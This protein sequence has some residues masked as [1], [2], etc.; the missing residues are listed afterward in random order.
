MRKHI[1]IDGIELI[2]SDDG[3]VWTPERDIVYS[4]GRKCHYKEK[5]LHPSTTPQGYK[6]IA[7]HGEIYFSFH[8]HRLIAI[9][10]IPN[11][12]NLSCV[13]HKDG[14][15]QNNHVSNLEWC[16]VE[17]NNKH[18]LK[19]GLIGKYNPIMCIETGEMFDSL[20]ECS[21]RFNINISYLG[22][23]LKGKYKQCKGHH[24]KFIES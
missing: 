15:K 16:T 4:N 22:K 24:F 7:H 12:N 14:N 11:P 18:A 5:E 9:T 10:F 2:V 3:R 8:V 13:N 17:Y 1:N 19:T 21:R 23:H 20:S 6:R